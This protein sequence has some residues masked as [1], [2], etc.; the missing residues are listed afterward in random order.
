MEKR[1]VSPC[2]TGS[3][4]SRSFL[5]L[6]ELRGADEGLKS[7]AARCP[8]GSTSTPSLTGCLQAGGHGKGLRKKLKPKRLSVT[9]LCI[10]IEIKLKSSHQR[11]TR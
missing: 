4:T 2:Y 7:G 8:G 9:K 5:Y 1:R 3:Y 11:H 6:L 10:L